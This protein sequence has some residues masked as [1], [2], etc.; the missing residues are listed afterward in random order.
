MPINRHIPTINHCHSSNNE[1]FIGANAIPST[2]TVK[3]LEIF[4]VI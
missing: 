4:Q 1:Y 2:H 3:E